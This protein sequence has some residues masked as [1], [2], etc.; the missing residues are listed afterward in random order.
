[1]PPTDLAAWIGALE[2]AVADLVGI[3]LDDHAGR[4]EVEGDAL[5]LRFGLPAQA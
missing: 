1:M 5:V 3:R 4:W 2:E